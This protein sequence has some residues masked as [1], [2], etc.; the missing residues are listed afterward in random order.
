MRERQGSIRPKG[1]GK[2]GRWLE[3]HN[4]GL[5]SA[6]IRS[7][8]VHREAFALYVETRNRP[9]KNS[10]S[11]ESPR[12]TDTQHAVRVLMTRKLS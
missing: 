12:K 3:P 9:A 6:N 5:K 7:G 10:H 1:G 2:E 4:N 11:E 8:V